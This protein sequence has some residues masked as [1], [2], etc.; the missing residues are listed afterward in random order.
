MSREQT[1]DPK[2]VAV[3]PDA[4]PD[5]SNPNKAHE[6]AADSRKQDGRYLQAA[7]MRGRLAPRRIYG[8]E[9]K[10]KTGVGEMRTKSARGR[11]PGV[12]GAR[13]QPFYA[14]CAAGHGTR[15]C[16]RFADEQRSGRACGH[17]PCA[18]THSRIY[19]LIVN[20]YATRER[21]SERERRRGVEEREGE[22]AVGR[23]SV[24]VCARERARSGA[25]ERPG[26]R[27]DGYTRRARGR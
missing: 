11:L 2:C 15:P 20:K 6:P 17:P 7:L 9:E 18:H 25:S 3:P 4:T 16:L 22:L 13:V 12:V 21:K 8:S 19:S 24:R 26:K 14:R 23:D 5:P 10:K 1:A 27:H